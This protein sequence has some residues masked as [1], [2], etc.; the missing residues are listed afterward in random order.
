ML[1]RLQRIR[2]DNT[3]PPT[4]PRTRLSTAMRSEPTY[5]RLVMTATV[6][7]HAHS[8]R[9]RV[10]LDGAEASFIEV[11]YN[12]DQ[13]SGDWPPK[14]GKEDTAAQL[15]G[16]GRYVAVEWFDDAEGSAIRR[17][18]TCDGPVLTAQQMSQCAPVHCPTSSRSR[19]LSLSLS[20]SCLTVSLCSSDCLTV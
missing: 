20:C 3:V 9:C 12:D 16:T 14:A 15:W 5:R 10:L 6:P 2:R 18:Q 17:C 11:D 1:D 13:S 19:S 8:D 7:M 4:L